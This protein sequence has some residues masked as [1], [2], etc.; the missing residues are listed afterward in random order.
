MSGIGGEV[1]ELDKLLTVMLDAQ[2]NLKRARD[3]E[4]VEG[5][6][7]EGRKL[8]VGR[9]LVARAMVRR[10]RTVSEDDVE[11]LVASNRTTRNESPNP[12]WQVKLSPSAT[13]SMSRQLFQLS[14]ECCSELTS[15]YNSSRIVS[16]SLM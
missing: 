8:E 9:S 12:P 4:K 15:L 5:E 10:D 1:G 13:S 14:L 16:A 7:K 6:S 3:D 2:K 11:E